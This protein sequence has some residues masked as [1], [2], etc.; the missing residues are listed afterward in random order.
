MFPTLLRIGEFRLATYGV[1]VAAGYL[2]GISWL[3]KNRSRMGLGEEDFWNLIYW[4]FG[5]ALVGG[6]LLYLAV[7]W[8]SVMDGTLSPLR[9]LR[10]GFVFY[11]GV[12]GSMTAGII[13]CRRH[14]SSFAKIADYI[15][16]AL[17]FGHAI[18]RF[19]CLAA[20]CCAGRP[21][22]MPWGI[23]F[24]NPEAL[25]DPSM[26]AFALHPVQIYESA[27][28]LAVTALVFFTLGKVQSG[29]LREG[30]AFSVYLGAYGVARFCL[31]GF[32]G[33]DRGQGF[34]G[35]SPAQIL[36]VVTL[37]GVAV[38]LSRRRTA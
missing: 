14:G 16:V 12:F 11:G 25:V 35:F 27:A 3:S 4:L 24:T 33:D 5:G 28:D 37:S 30:A 38:F 34:W 7:E 22:A 8:R 13:W 17:P 9:D 2:L 10:Y 21:T 29:N 18:G 1:L 6:K 23:R 36:A 26:A 15:G 19:G 20:G 31:E 32:R